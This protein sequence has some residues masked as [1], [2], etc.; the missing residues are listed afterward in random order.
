MSAVRPNSWWVMVSLAVI[1]GLLPLV[2]YWFALGRVPTVSADEARR[3]LTDHAADAALVDV[4]TPEEYAA[5]HL[6]AAR[7]WPLAEIQAAAA[8]TA[9][10]EALRGKQLVLICDSGLQ[11]GRAAQR[12][13]QLGLA[14]AVNVEGGM[15]A[16]VTGADK[17]CALAFCR[18]RRDS[19][20]TSELPFRPASRWE[21]T[22]AVFTGFF[23]KP[24]YMFLSLVIAVVL[25]RQRALDLLALRWA[26]LA[27]FVGEA[28]CAVNYLT[29]GDRSAL[30][31]YL[32]SYGMVLCFSLTMFAL[33]EGLDLRLVRYSD[34]Q[35]R[36][37]AVALCHRCIKH[38]DAPC[39]LQRTFLLM[40]PAAM[41]LCGMPF[42]AELLPGSYNTRI[43]GTFYSYGHPV[44]C[45]LFEIRYLPGAA[46][47]LLTL[48]WI[49]LRFN[50][51]SGVWWSK[52]FFAAGSG[53]LGFALFRLILLQVYRD[54][55]VWYAGWEEFTELL[56]VLS[57]GLVLWIF[58]Q[59]LFFERP[60]TGPAA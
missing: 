11:S 25:W 43:F 29:T 26:M 31:E 48:A 14:G 34:P 27:F 52:L 10:P 56:F 39:G 30:L 57:L 58:R 16:W 23:V 7:N 37:A 60:A 53:A 28:F 32:H 6:E 15:Q 2:A 46:L 49:A 41:V 12:L 22:V 3:L 50:A 36:C 24:L 40:I 20:E 59:G 5:G 33:L 18:L 47:V 42:C 35:A 55:Q 44:L 19:G 13:H 54:N 1:G 9:V 8:A 17:P 4:R 38:V 45:Q 51:T 21:Q